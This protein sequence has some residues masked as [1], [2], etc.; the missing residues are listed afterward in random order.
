[1]AIRPRRDPP[2]ASQKQD[3]ATVILYAPR[4]GQVFQN[5]FPHRFV[6]ARRIVNRA[7][8]EQVL[9]VGSGTLGLGIADRLKPE[10][11]RQ[12]NE[13]ERN[14]GLLPPRGRLLA[15]RERQQ[16]G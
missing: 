9:S 8:D 13:C 1:M 14:N 6:P 16:V 10:A 12:F 4:Q 7:A 3:F 2:S 15:W 11:P 5:F